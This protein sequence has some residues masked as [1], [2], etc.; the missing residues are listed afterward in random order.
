MEQICTKAKHAADELRCAI[1]GTWTFPCT[2]EFAFALGHEIM[3]ALFHLPFWRAVGKNLDLP[4]AVIDDG[5]RLFFRIRGHYRRTRDYAVNP[6]AVSEEEVPL[7]LKD[8]RDFCEAVAATDP[9][10]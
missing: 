7:L 10:R 8:I 5:R 9:R 3:P 1:K 2:I 6:G 4:D